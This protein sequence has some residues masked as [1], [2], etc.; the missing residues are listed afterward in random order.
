[1]GRLCPRKTPNEAGVRVKKREQKP[2]RGGNA[3]TV[4]KLKVWPKRDVGWAQ[5]KKGEPKRPR[6]SSGTTGK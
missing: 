2:L 3:Y 6:S 1:V 4:D 5:K